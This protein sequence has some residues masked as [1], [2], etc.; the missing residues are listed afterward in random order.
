MIITGSEAAVGEG[1]RNALCNGRESSAGDGT[2]V[3]ELIENMH[4][5]VSYDILYETACELV[6]FLDLLRSPGGTT[7]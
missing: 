5:P 4:S 6:P 7:N 3:E 2:L 1:G